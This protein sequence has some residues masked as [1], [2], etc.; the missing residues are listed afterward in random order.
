MKIIISNAMV[1]DRVAETINELQSGGD[2]DWL[3]ENLDY[4]I[5]DLIRDYMNN[6]EADNPDEPQKY[7]PV[8]A[9]LVALARVRDIIQTIA[10]PPDSS[11]AANRVPLA[12]F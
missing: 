3:A 8:K 6:E 4:L 7:F 9:Y 10:L 5:R 12:Q 1:T 2:Y 11:A